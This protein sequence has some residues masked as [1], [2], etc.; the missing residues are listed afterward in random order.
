[1]ELKDIAKQ[2]KLE[3][4]IIS[5]DPYG[6][7]HINRTYLIKTNSNDYIFQRINS[8]AFKDVNML[9]N[10]INYVTNYLKENNIE[11]MNIIKT[12]D[13]K[14]YFK[15]DDSYY[16]VYD[17]NGHTVFYEK[18]ESMELINKTAYAFGL[19]HKQLKGL[20][21]TK[22]GEIIPGFHNTKQRYLNFLSALKEDKFNLAKNCTREINIINKY[23]ELYS[24]FID[25][26]K[27][28][29][30][31][32]RIT[33]NDPKINNI[34][35]DATTDDVRVVIDLDTIMPGSALY[36]VGDAFRSLFTGDNEDNK[37][38]SILKVNYK[39]FENYLRGYFK[40][41]GDELTPKEV[42]LIPYAPFI[43]TIECGIRFLEDYLRGNVYFHVN[44]DE[45]NLVRCRTQL[46][47]A[48]DIIENIEKL[49]EIVNKIYMEK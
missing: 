29:E 14:L 34:L 37:D 13:D 10:N 15:D 3:G 8:V 18:I 30:I 5:I 1:M 11:S 45:H 6:N 17:F 48:E 33:H 38:Y 28:E 16:R 4:K 49:K 39:L 31:P 36:D 22:I 27:N 35:F 7:G 43:L 41:M 25:A 21:V 26:L 40:A 44:Y 24:M 12:L 23:K 47:L 32:T 9:M 2:F 46:A 42:E 19:F 20:D